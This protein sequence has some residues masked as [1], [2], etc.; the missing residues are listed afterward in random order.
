MTR[1]TSRPSFTTRS[2][3]CEGAD[4]RRTVSQQQ[5]QYRFGAK[6]NAFTKQSGGRQEEVENVG[7]GPQ[8][9]PCD[10]KFAKGRDYD[11]YHHV[12]SFLLLWG[13]GVASV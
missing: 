1:R 7:R 8:H 2:R 3:D 9:T 13:G 11:D 12:K 6:G 5:Q 4:A 10:R